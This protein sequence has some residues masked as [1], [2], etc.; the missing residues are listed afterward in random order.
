VP[1]VRTGPVKGLLAQ[2]ALLMGLYATVGLGAAGLCAGVLYGLVTSALLTYGMRSTGTDSLGPADGV[3]Y[4]RAVLIG[5]VV[6]L[7][8][9]SFTRATPVAVLVVLT[10][11]ALALDWVDGQVARRTGTSSVL[12]A[13]FDMEVDAFLLLVLGVYLT[14][15]LGAWVLTIGFMRYGFVVA[16]W[17][18]PW[19]RWPLPQRYWAKVAAAVQGIALLVAA[20]GVLSHGVTILVVA[21]ALGLLIESF[22]THVVRLWKMRTIVVPV[23]FTREGAELR[24]AVTTGAT[25]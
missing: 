16:S 4:G 9:D 15:S 1:N 6:A 24:D 13:R 3:T 23:E 10:G 25:R 14:P 2:L 22:G 19:L 7:T 21:A 20:S 17:V 8:A 12:G 5:G 18:L 11:V